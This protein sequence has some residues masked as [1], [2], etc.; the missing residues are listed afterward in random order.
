MSVEHESLD[1]LISQFPQGCVL[2]VNERGVTALIGMGISRTGPGRCEEL[3]Q[4]VTIPS[5]LQAL[6]RAAQSLVFM[7]LWDST[8][9]TFYAGILGWPVDPMR[10]F[11][12]NDLLSLSI[13]GGILTAEVTHF[14]VTEAQSDL[15][16]TMETCASTLLCTMNHLLD[17]SKI[18]DLDRAQVHGRRKS[19]MNAAQGSPLERFGQT[20]EDYLCRVV[21]DIVD[22]VAFGH[23]REQAAH[24]KD[25]TGDRQSS[26]VR[27]DIEE[28]LVITDDVAVFLFM[29]SHAAWFS[30]FSAG[31]WKRL[32]MNLFGNALKFC[33]SGHIEVTLELMPDPKAPNRKMAH[34][35]VRDTGIGM[36][37]EFIKHSLARPFAQA[38]SLISETGLGLSIVK[39]IVDDMQGVINIESTLGT[40][41]QFDVFVPV[42]DRESIPKGVTL[43]GG[44]VLDPN[45]SFVVL[46]FA[47][48][49][50]I[51]PQKTARMYRCSEPIWCKLT[52]R[53]S[54]RTGSIR[55]LCMPNRQKRSMQISMLLKLWTTPWSTETAQ[56]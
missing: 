46:R 38:N 31:A 1:Y 14:D 51:V 26:K 30:M 6:L 52:S 45:V 36:S 23:D 10:V 8:R 21:Q 34:L 24:D 13:Y 37:E 35:M 7:P 12:E 9:Q 39:R 44:Q 16:G 3:D 17:F 15:L 53:G 25:M 19:S 27:F 55:R 22:G 18:N 5:D 49:R 50:L 47:C 28:E 42:L 43:D 2:K 4:A 41:S 11:T 20:S 56:S 54:P 33:S 48:L 29:E 40:G 32:V